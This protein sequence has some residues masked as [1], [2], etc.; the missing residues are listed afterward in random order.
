MMSPGSQVMNWDAK[1]MI[2]A[3]LKIMSAVEPFCQTLSL[4]FSSMSRLL[5]SGF[6]SSVVVIHGPHAAKPSIHLPLSQS[7]NS[8]KPPGVRPSTFQCMERPEM[9]LKTV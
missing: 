1:E 2:S 4:T 5:G 6:T 3:G 7:K 9:S 8:S